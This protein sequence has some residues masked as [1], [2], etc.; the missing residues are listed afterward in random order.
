M[1]LTETQ[2]RKIEEEKKYRTQIRGNLVS[3]RYPRNKRSKG[4]ATFLAIFF[5]GIGIHK[6]YLGRPWWGLTYIIFSWAFIPL[7]LGFL[8]GIIYLLMSDK[9]FE[10]KYS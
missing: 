1:T 2:K 9:S 8:E 5:G 4:L 10:Q 6:F 7:I 3:E